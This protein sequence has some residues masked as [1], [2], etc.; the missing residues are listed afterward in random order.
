MLAF[1]STSGQYFTRPLLEN[2]PFLGA[3]LVVAE[4]VLGGGARGRSRT[5]P[6]DAD[7]AVHHA[8]L[9]GSSLAVHAPEAPFLAGNVAATP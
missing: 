8:R 4:E 5:A 7:D 9:Q 2:R 3:F 1:L 6:A